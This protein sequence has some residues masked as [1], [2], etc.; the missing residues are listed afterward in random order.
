MSDLSMD[1]IKILR[2]RT[3]VGLTKCKEALSQCQGDVEEAIVYLRKLGLASSSKKEH[4]ETKEGVVIAETDGHGIAVIEVNVETD[5]VANNEHFRAF[6]QSL[7]HDVLKHQVTSVEQLQ[8]LPSSQE[9]SLTIEEQ[10]AVV[11]QMLGENIRINRV[12]YLP[13]SAD[14]VSGIYSH[15][16]GKS[17]AVTIL[18]GPANAATLA[19]DI[20][21]QVVASSPE[22]LDPSAVPNEILEKEKDVVRSLNFVEVARWSV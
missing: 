22:Y 1:K 5:F 18:N 3:G 19:K 14:Q 21:L 15:G 12:S 2:E 10:R 7:A 17:V 6:A 11:M 20:A 8:Q 13:L 16:N 9:P 4:R